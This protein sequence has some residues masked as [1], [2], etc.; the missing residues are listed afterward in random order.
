MDRS[1]MLNSYVRDNEDNLEEKEN[2]ED[3]LEK[4]K[5]RINGS[6][7]IE[8][9]KREVEIFLEKND[10]PSQIHDDLIKICDDFNETTDLYHAE[11]YLEDYLSN[12]LQQ[13][14][15]DY[16]KST[17]TIHD[18][19][20]ELVEES[21]KQLDSVGITMSGSTDSV[22]DKIQSE[23]DVYKLKN[24]VE[25]AVEFFDQRNAIFGEENVST[26]EIPIKTIEEAL[27]KPSQETVLEAALDEQNVSNYHVNEVKVNNDGSVVIQGDANN[28]ESMNFAALITTALVT[29]NQ[30]LG[31][32]TNLDMKFIKEPEHDSTFK[33]IYGDFP[34]PAQT[35]N[36]VGSFIAA[37]VGEL[38]KNY[39]SQVSYME[40]L[41]T[42][43]PELMTALTLIQEQILKEKGAFQMAV[44]NGG[45]HHEMVFAVDEN[46]ADVSTAFYE[47]G[48][49]VSHDVM[50]HSIIRVNNTTPGEQLMILSA[51][52]E[53]LRQKE[54]E[55]SLVNQNNYQKQLVYPSQMNEA[56]NVYSVFLTV[57]SI[58]EL[59]LISVFLYILF[60]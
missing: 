37:K 42:K 45:R 34:L 52:L 57:V 2:A 15:N 50:E 19:K 5:F 49:M 40:L 3:Y 48:A 25:T 30:D 12:Y 60:H 1:Y 41:G 32:D 33:I 8:E 29:S 38:T 47:S 7:S 43:S 36:A 11:K 55:S 26:L 16:Q 23:D 58:A 22:L 28:P 44:K 51:T 20:E 53:N 10:V 17:D 13:K 24:N 59:L 6:K 56:A 27:E 54:M 39:Q 35:N 18:I 21:K 31:M 4:L 9:I 46:Y 14:E